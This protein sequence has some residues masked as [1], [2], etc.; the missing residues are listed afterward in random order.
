M[1]EEKGERRNEKYIIDI[2]PLSYLISPIS[3]Q[4]YFPLP[5]ITII[6]V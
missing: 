5:C 3:S 6:T 1:R 2:S 4:N